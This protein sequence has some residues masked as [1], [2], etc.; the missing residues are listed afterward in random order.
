MEEPVRIEDLPVQVDASAVRRHLRL[1][2]ESPAAPRVTTLVRRLQAAARPRA[3]Y[4][5]CRIEGRRGEKV[6]IEGID[7]SSPALAVLLDSA[8][9]VFPYVVTVGPEIDEALSL[10]SGALERF[11]LDT[12]GNLVLQESVRAMERAIAACHGLGTTGRIGP[13]AGDGTLWAIEEQDALFDLLGD[14]TSSIGV[15]LTADHLMLPVKSLSGMLFPTPTG[16]SDCGICR[17]VDCPFRHAPY[18][19]GLHESLAA[20]SAREE[21]GPA[22]A[23]E[24]DD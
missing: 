20:G 23:V 11:V 13:G 9:W 14:V 8:D 17:S 16:F 6:R 7:F 21:P 24:R 1:K 2:D 5:A 18:D 12:T 15:S 10:E 22:S 4:R 19:A 3:L